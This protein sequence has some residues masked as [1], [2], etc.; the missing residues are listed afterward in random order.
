MHYMPQIRAHYLVSFPT[1]IIFS[2]G[3]QDFL[4]YMAKYF[5]LI[6]KSPSLIFQRSF[7][8]NHSA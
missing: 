5:L 3:F 1:V 6:L 4:I 2:T 7:S 8:K